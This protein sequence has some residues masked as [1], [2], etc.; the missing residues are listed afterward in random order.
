MTQ[1]QKYAI[2]LDNL[3][4][5]HNYTVDHFCSDIVDSRTFRRYK[6]GE[7][8]LSHTKIAQFCERLKIS[9]AD[10]YFA[11]K[12]DDEIETRKILSIYRLLTERNYKQLFKEASKIDRDYIF[13]I[14]NRRLYD[15]TIA[16]AKYD[17]NLI[18]L[19]EAYDVFTSVADYPT[20]IDYK[21]F[22]FVSISALVIISEFEVKVHK[23]SALQL[24]MDILV[25]PKMIYASEVNSNIIPI[26]YLDVCLYLLRLHRFKAANY[27][28]DSGIKFVLPRRVSTGL[29]FFYYT[30]AYA[31]LMLDDIKNAEI[32]AVRCLMTTMG[33][34][35][36]EDIERF[37]R[38]LKKDFNKDPY[39]FIEHHLKSLFDET[40][41]RQQKIP[42]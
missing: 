4:R 36:D 2:Q 23:E 42:K 10:F 1:S 17:Q 30:K 21:M 18:T 22:D 11:S 8:T 38:I 31:L 14:Q 6:T 39:Q 9:T 29:A 37:Y 13:E 5:K 41:E 16:K 3:R 19:E 25:T 7:K 15:F 33:E 24:L 20:C 26:I 27:M 34:Q 28:A 40:I 32:N 35:R 12:N